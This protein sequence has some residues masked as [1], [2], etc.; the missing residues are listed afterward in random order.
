[1]AG[2]GGRGKRSAPHTFDKTR[3]EVD[4]WS[5]LE[6]ERSWPPLPPDVV[7]RYAQDGA[8]AMAITSFEMDMVCEEGCG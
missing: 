3:P 1:M 8:P 6:E 2:T 5:Y 4:V 7:A